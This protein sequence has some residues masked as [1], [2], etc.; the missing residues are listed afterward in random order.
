MP[1]LPPASPLPTSTVHQQ[2]THKYV[3]N[4]PLQ[5]ELYLIDTPAD[6]S[7]MPTPS[8]KLL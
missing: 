1:A 3:P 8:P 7:Y 5:E 4:S 6:D 2:P